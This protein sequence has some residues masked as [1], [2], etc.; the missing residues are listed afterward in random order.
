LTNSNSGKTFDELYNELGAFDYDESGFTINYENFTKRIAWDDITQL[1]VYKVDQFTVDRIDMEI[2]YGGK[3]LTISEELP[4]WYQFV[5]KTKE[6]FPTI[7]KNW[8]TEII[9]PAFS[10]N[11]A[12]IYDITK[13]KERPE[14]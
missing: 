12:T 5:L 4:G 14:N 10:T 2:V 11:Y 7:P 9:P 8:D 13:L 6:I 3:A 1:N